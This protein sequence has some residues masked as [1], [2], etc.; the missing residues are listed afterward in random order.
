MRKRYGGR[1]TSE[2]GKSELGE[3]SVSSEASP[4]YK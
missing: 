1:T 3:A 2:P 4:R